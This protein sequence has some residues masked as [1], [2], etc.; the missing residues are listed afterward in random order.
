M[1]ILLL[2]NKNIK[3]NKEHHFC[4]NTISIEYAKLSI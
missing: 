2:L 4:Y 1:D 3:Q